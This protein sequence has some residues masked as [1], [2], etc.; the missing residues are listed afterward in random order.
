MPIHE[1]QWVTDV[2]SWKSQETTAKSKT[3]VDSSTK[4][5]TPRSIPTAA[6]AD[7]S[8]IS[9]NQYLSTQV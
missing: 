8:N 7:Q 4:L 9:Y 6:T 5:T 3:W 2:N 1:K